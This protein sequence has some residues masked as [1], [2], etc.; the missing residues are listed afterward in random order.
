[1][2]RSVST[3]TPSQLERKRVRD[4][5]AQ[6]A[7]RA[8]TKQHIERL[9]REI[10]ELAQQNKVLEEGL[11]LLQNS[12]RCSQTGL[13]PS[14]NPSFVSGFIP[15]PQP[16]SV[17]DSMISGSIVEPGPSYLLH[18]DS[19]ESQV[20]AVPISILC[21]VSVP[22]PCTK[23]GRYSAARPPVEKWVPSME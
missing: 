6:R 10:G 8:K 18:P 20:S 15:G 1:G 2:R 11:V 5:E 23:T 17:H 14:L 4:R 19:S 21:N 3:L 9:E 12:A 16:Y 13:Y 7:T 22:F